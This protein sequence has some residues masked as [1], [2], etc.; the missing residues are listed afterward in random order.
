MG[1]ENKATAAKPL[2]AID[3]ASLRVFRPWRSTYPVRALGWFGQAGDQLQ[4]RILGG[5]VLVL[6][7]AKHDVGLMRAAARMLIAH[8]IAT[9]AKTLLKS[10][11]IVDDRG[12]REARRQS[13][14][15]GVTTKAGL[16][17][18]S[19]QDIAPEAQ[20]VGTH[21]YRLRLLDEHGGESRDIEFEAS[22]AEVA[23]RMAHQYCGRRKV[24][25]LEDGRK[26]ADL[27]LA[28]GHGFWI[29]SEHGL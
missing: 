24:Q 15:T 27:R 1:K 12:T 26:L 10:S 19:L 17:T 13:D 25:L 22:D 14:R 21:V 18:A 23:L 9:L 16:A 5:G 6:G 2:L 3:H 28:S 8:E 29:I 4:L 11:S 7:L 20:S